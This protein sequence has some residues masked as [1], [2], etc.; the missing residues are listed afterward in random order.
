VPI[1][2]LK[3]HELMLQKLVIML[4]KNFLGIPGRHT[5]LI[6]ALR[7]AQAIGYKLQKDRMVNSDLL[8]SLRMAMIFVNIK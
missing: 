3:D 4:N 6:R 2:F 7:T 1:S 8:D 5:E